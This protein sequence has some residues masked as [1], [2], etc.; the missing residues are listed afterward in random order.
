MWNLLRTS[1][2]L[3][4][5]FFFFLCVF[6][7]PDTPTTVGMSFHEHLRFIYLFSLWHYQNVCS[8]TSSVPRVVDLRDYCSEDMH[9]R[10]WCPVSL[11]VG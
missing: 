8:F 10:I 3:S 5:H 1:E 6:M 2:L 7:N 9:V 11:Q 4:R